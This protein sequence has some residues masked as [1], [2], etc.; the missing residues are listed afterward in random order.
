MIIVSLGSSIRAVGGKEEEEEGRL[1]RGAKC[2]IKKSR[3]IPIL[4]SQKF[5]GLCIN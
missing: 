3:T 1:V 5:I 2:L 4:S